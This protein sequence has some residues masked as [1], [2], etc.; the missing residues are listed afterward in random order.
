MPDFIIN[1]SQ[2]DLIIEN[3]QSM[4]RKISFFQN[5]VNEFI[6]SVKTICGENEIHNTNS[7]LMGHLNWDSC[8]KIEY[9]ESIKVD[10]VTVITAKHSNKEIEENSFFVE[11]TVYIHNMLNYVDFDDLIGYDLKSY[12]RNSL[13]KIPVSIKFDVKRSPNN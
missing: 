10:N 11:V 4:N 1:Q 7:A 12:L 8:D 6:G 3:G 13:G 5:M 2:L 9:I